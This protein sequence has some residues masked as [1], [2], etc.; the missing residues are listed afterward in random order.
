MRRALRRALDQ[1][2]LPR[3]ARIEQQRDAAGLPETD[4]GTEAV[5]HAIIEWLGLAQDQSRSHDG[6]VARDYSLVKG[7]AT[8]YPETTGY[9]IPTFLAYARRTGDQRTR[10][11]ALRM[12]DWLVSIQFP[13]GGFQGGKIGSEPVVPVTFNTGQI[14]LGLAA[15]QEETGLYAEPMRRAADWLVRTQDADG[16]WRSHQSPFAST[17][18]KQYETHVAWGLFEAGRIDTGRGYGAAG[19]KNV[20]WAIEGAAPNGWLPHCCLT[21]KARPLTHTLGYA[22]RGVIEAHRFE[23]HADLLEA[24]DRTAHGL[25]GAL[26]SDGFLPGRLASDWSAAAD[27]ACLTGTAQV[28]HCWLLLHQLTG[29]S[30]YL[31]GAL[32]ANTYVRR[33]VRL[34]GPPAQRGAVKGSFPVN[35]QYGPFEYLNWASKFAADSLMLEAD[36]LGAVEIA[37]MRQTLE[38]ARPEGSAAAVGRQ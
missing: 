29:E 9:I 33:T 23:P 28:A 12:T 11:R 38:P 16:C 2:S 32:Q 36:V 17:G 30:H 24:A 7:W 5:L 15:A 31:Q 19:M 35:G 14:L 18:D 22:L 6:G 20:R 8:S 10:A 37:Q 3:A 25:L 4:H 26:R 1:L 34:D 21:D 27:W 13:D